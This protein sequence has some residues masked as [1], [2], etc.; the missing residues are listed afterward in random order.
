M[1][2][3]K[4][5]EEPNPL[6]STQ[7][8]IP[9]PNAPCYPGLV[10]VVHRVRGRPR[11]ATRSWVAAADRWGANHANCTGGSPGPDWYGFT[12]ATPTS[13]TTNVTRILHPIALQWSKRPLIKITI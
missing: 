11:V 12:R 1:S 2:R 10:D 3:L 13:P 7:N 9:I 8:I 6:L 4:L 5:F